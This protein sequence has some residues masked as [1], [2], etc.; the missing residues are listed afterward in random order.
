VK[1]NVKLQF[2]VILVI[3][4][5]TSLRQWLVLILTSFLCSCSM[6]SSYSSW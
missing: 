6:R 5:L 3:N 4:A 1:L 2:V